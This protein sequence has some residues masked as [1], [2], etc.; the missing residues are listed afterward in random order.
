[1]STKGHAAANGSV[2]ANGYVAASG[3]VSANG[4]VAA[5]GYIAYKPT[6]LK[7]YRPISI[8]YSPKEGGAAAS[9]AAHPLW[10]LYFD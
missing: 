7:T 10:P 2:A 4:Y 8:P 6:D 5:N 9:A 1:M 3:Y